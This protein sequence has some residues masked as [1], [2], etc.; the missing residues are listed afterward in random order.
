MTKIAE[1]NKVEDMQ[2][3]IKEALEFLDQHLPTLYVS[4]V[5]KRL[6]KD[7][8]ITS[9]IIR[10]VRNQSS[11][12]TENKLNVLNALVEVAKENK[13]QKEILIESLK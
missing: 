2:T 3:H 10:N 1:K 5:K 9:G 13:I 8:G 12:I 6:A 4:E 7:S 11:T